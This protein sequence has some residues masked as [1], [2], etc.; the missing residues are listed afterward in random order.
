MPAQITPPP[1]PGEATSPALALVN[2]EVAPQ[3]RPVDLIP[4]GPTLF[5]WMRTR[6]LTHRGAGPIADQDLDRMRTL[7]SAIRVAFTARAGGQ[8]APRSAI[9][10]INEAAALASSMPRLRWAADRPTRETVWVPSASATDTALAEIAS[11]AIST[12]LGDR[13]DRLRLCEA[14]D[15]SRMF[16][17][18]HR[19]R[20][21]C[22]Q[23]CG[24]R[25]RVAR[26]RKVNRT[27]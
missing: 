14:H 21:W 13:G 16:I 1:A 5:G 12:L 7:R 2:T 17:A 25:M 10:A 9:E 20:R 27:R 11:N 23:T 22:S 3:G 8:R 15:C 26:H 6:G 24:D 19:R 18:D 4:D